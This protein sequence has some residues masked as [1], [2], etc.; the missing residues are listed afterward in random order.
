MAFDVAREIRTRFTAD[1]TQF[2]AAV[3]GVEKRLGTLQQ[4]TDRSADAS[5]RLNSR[6][7]A[8]G[9]WGAAAFVVQRLA[10]TVGRFGAEM[11]QAQVQAERL[12]TSLTFGG[13]A[14]ASQ[15]IGYLQAV[16]RQLGLDF[17]TTA[18]SYAKFS[19][20][21]R[22][23]ALEGRGTREVFES[24]AKAATVMGLSVDEAQGVLLALQQMVSKG[25]VQAEELRG[26]LGER[27][28]GAF[29]IAARAMGVTTAEL[30]KMLE[31]GKILADDF[32]P[33]FARQLDSE[34][35]ASAEKASQRIEASTIRLGNA[36]EQLKKD[37]AASGVGSFI[38][39]QLTILEDAMSDASRSM[40]RAR[41]EGGGFM[42]QML[43]LGGATLRFL[44]PLNAVAYSAQNVGDKLKTA[45]AE[46]AQLQAQMR[47]QPGDIVLAHMLQ[48]AER[49]VATL[50]EAETVQKQLLVDQNPNETARFAGT[51]N[52]GASERARMA[53]FG[54]RGAARDTYVKDLATD[55]E[56]LRAELDK[57]RTAFEGFIPPD[58]EARI[59]DKFDKPLQEARAALAQ[60][61]KGLADQREQLILQTIE[62]NAGAVAAQQYRAAQL[63]AG[64]ATL[65]AIADNDALARALSAQR[66]EREAVAEAAQ[67]AID[68][69]EK[70]RQ[71][72]EKQIK[73]AREMLADIEQETA[74]LRMNS[75]EREVAIA[76]RKLETE[77]I[78]KGTQ[79]YE[80][81]AD[82]IRGAIL[83]R[84]QVRAG[85]DAARQYAEDVKRLAESI[86]NTITD[87]LMDAF[88]S[89][90]SFAQS[91]RDTLENMF[92]TLVLR[93]VIQAIVMP[94]GMAASGM[95]SAAG[96]GGGGAMGS[97]SL[98]WL[99]QLGGSFGIGDM[100]AMLGNF[101][102]GMGV[103]SAAG[104][105]GIGSVWNLGTGLMGS[106]ATAGGAGAL[107][108]GLGTLAA[109]GFLGY[110][111]GRG[112]SGDYSLGGHGGLAPG[113]GAVIGTLVAGPIGGAIGGAIGGLV[114]R[115]FGR[116]SKQTDSTGITGTIF[117]G[118]FSG[119]NF[120][121]WHQKGGWFRSDKSGTDN[122]PLGADIA[123]A[124]NTSAAAVLAQTQGYAHALGLPAHLLGKVSDQ[125]RIQLGQDEQANQAAIDKA[126][127]GYQE[128][129]SGQF[130]TLLKPLQHAGETLTATFARLAGLQTFS[131]G[132][133]ELGGVFS[134]IANLG[135]DAR[136]GL[137]ALA[138]G[139][140]VL[141]AQSRSYIEQYY[142][143]D[144]LAG[145]KSREIRNVLTG[146]GITQDIGT[147]DQFRALVEGVD[148]K[149]DKGRQQL[150][151][152]LG[153]SSSFAGL[154][155][156]FAETG[157]TLGSASGNAPEIGTLGSLFASGA[158]DQVRAT[159]AVQTAIERVRD[160]LLR[161]LREGP[162]AGP[163]PPAVPAISWTDQQWEVSTGGN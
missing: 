7:G 10:A 55:A 140:D 8:I 130:S 118:N 119:R 132:L 22:G 69:D 103:G 23:T 27:L 161:M 3:A 113:V 78:V 20:A 162:A 21:A 83:T 90:K 56:R 89:G 125:I 155:D 65:Q 134:H 163:A 62:F 81:F 42:S 39:G 131:A 145:L 47:Q 137:I 48:V 24:V 97:S 29:Q 68:A 72:N 116:G 30:G 46:L 144:E 123:A 9:Q 18:T 91:F 82:A 100:G 139:M 13:A 66:R 147:R 6:I 59:R 40:Q 117:D 52:E 112:I 152:L 127:A 61:T 63:G 121:D 74:L 150:A 105:S 32:L 36:W 159:N 108:G 58:I 37:A 34:L 157:L 12:Q 4:S 135:V 102:A 156:Y 138:G 17:G 44:Q 38:G 110:G 84:E 93:P 141:A 35:G 85:V 5:E 25:T 26:Q 86:G 106:G 28:P 53:R 45:E 109:G 50:R 76:M 16:T 115:A 1:A 126:F 129:L 75:T 70:N 79:A 142:S 133:N 14:A 67:A 64:K 57:A 149:S 19:A 95:A 101:G 148:L 120:A 51:E 122:S 73:T 111:I 71:A 153:V 128:K 107:V 33:R 98:G 99:G 114:N 94:V 92:K 124:L 80:A 15:E 31:Q 146:V 154:T 96:G 87:K 43:A 143:R 77:G 49:Y 136:E 41:N 158:Q 160:V 88:A 60:F 54:R 11:L 104:M 151:A 2:D